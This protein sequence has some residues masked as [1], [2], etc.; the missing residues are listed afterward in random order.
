[1]KMSKYLISVVLLLSIMLIG[2]SDDATEGTS[3]DT[4]QSFTVINSASS[5]WRITELY[6]GVSGEV[7]GS[8]DVGDGIHRGQ[9]LDFDVSDEGCNKQWEV[10]AV[11]NDPAGTECRQYK[12]VE[13]GKTTVFTFNNND[14][15]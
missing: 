15:S 4:K 10:N 7:I 1:M 8:L 14:C 9:S 11:Y 13:C 3:D 6:A 5:D 12:Q 2:C